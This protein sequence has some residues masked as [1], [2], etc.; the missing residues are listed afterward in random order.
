MSERAYVVEGMS[1]EHCS[2]AVR[3]EVGQVAGVTAVSVDLGSGALV[4]SGHAVD[5]DAVAAAVARAGYQIGDGS[6]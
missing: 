2:A 5:D 4:V 6:Q 1:C 3:D